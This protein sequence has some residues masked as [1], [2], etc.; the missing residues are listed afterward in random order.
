[1]STEGSDA[2]D[3]QIEVLVHSLAGDTVA[4]FSAK[5]SETVAGIK[6]HL[7]AQGRMTVESSLVL[8]SGEIPAD[9]A[10]L[11]LLRNES[12]QPLTLNL[13]SR[14]ADEEFKQTLPFHYR[15]SYTAGFLNCGGTAD[16]TVKL[17][18]DTFRENCGLPDG[19]KEQ[20]LTHLEG[21]HRDHALVLMQHTPEFADALKAAIKRATSIKFRDKG[22]WTVYG[23]ESRCDCEALF[24]LYY[25]N[26]WWEYEL[27]SDDDR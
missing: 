6:D 7:L 4:T 11:G 16:I 1:M 27:Y 18:D 9:N 23:N 12:D 10:E 17:V 19:T 8:V 3:D 2:A 20:L 26:I 15:M 5:K 22:R 25:V 24:D 13:V 14:S 21:G